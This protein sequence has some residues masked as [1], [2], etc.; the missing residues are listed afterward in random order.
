MSLNTEY[1]AT[2]QYLYEQLPM[3]QRIGPAAFK[4]DLGNIIALLEALGN[5]QEH[6]RAI[7]IGGTNGK[8]SVAHMLSAVL[9]TQGYRTGLYISPHYRDFRERIKVNGKYIRKKAVVAFVEEHREL[10]ERVRPS[11][12]EITV[13]MAFVYFRQ[14]KVDVAIVEVG[15]G[16]RLDSTNVLLPLLSVITNISL[17]HQQFLG[18][19]LPEIAGEKAGIIKPHT[20]VVIGETHPETQNVFT[21]KARALAAPISF[22]DQIWT[23]ELTDSDIAHSYYQI[24]RDSNTVYDRLAVN[25]QGDYQKFNIQTA[26]QA[27]SVLRDTEAL[28]ISPEAVVTGLADLKS[29]TRFIGRW[30]VIGQQ[31]TV[32]AD[33]A[34]NEGGLRIVLRQLQ[35]L[36]YR[37]LHIVMGTVNDKDPGKVLELFPKT[38]TYYFAKANVPRGMDALDLQ[39]RAADYG[40]EGRAYNSVRNA[41]R[42]A[43]RHAQPEDLIYVGGSIFVV[44]EV[45]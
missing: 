14:Q 5:P 7:H 19:T 32:L 28:Q 44:A 27:I 29:L 30:Q 12:F 22:A 8:G 38:A 9:Q 13:A 23:A 15:L 41:L 45:V 10:I 36:P 16:G 17:D 3:F 24:R 25:L 40:L 26:L 2:L 37:R 35:T 42:A 11:F 31:P 21:E 1:K 39:R 43:K 4:K 33:S 6:F 34:H 20:P 18:D